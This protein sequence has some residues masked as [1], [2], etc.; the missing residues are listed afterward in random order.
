MLKWMKMTVFQN[1]MCFRK[2]FSWWNYETFLKLHK[3][4]SHF[5]C[6]D[7]V[8]LPRTEVRSAM[9]PTGA[10]SSYS[11]ETTPCALRVSWSVTWDSE[12]RNCILTHSFSTYFRGENSLKHRFTVTLALQNSSLKIKSVLTCF[13][14][15]CYQSVQHQQESW[16]DS[17]QYSVTVKRKKFQGTVKLL[18]VLKV[19]VCTDSVLQPSE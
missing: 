19:N 10:P 13:G 7:F 11:G 9:E 12:E 17:T 15:F 8:L 1:Y 5:C 6:S 2:R 4:F 14:S 18:K 3:W 16:F